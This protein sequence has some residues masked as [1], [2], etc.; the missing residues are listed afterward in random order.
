MTPIKNKWMKQPLSN[1]LKTEYY[2]FYVTVSA[3]SIDA[4]LR[5]CSSLR[6]SFFVRD[7]WGCRRRVRFWIK[8]IEH[9][10]KETIGAERSITTGNKLDAEKKMNLTISF[11]LG[12][13]YNSLLNE[14]QFICLFFRPEVFFR[15]LKAHNNL[16]NNCFSFTTGADFTNAYVCD[17]R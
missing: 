8:A 16:C 15:Q 13:I 5:S 14:I 12:W 11:C 4:H 1:K 3:Q 10:G 17:H 7:F 6:W 9:A 2:F